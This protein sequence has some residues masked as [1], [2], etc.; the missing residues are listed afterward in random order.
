MATLLATPAAWPHILTERWAAPPTTIADAERADAFVAL[1]IAVRTLGPTGTIAEIAAS[2][3]RGRGGSG[4]PTADKWRTVSLSGGNPVVVVNGYGADPGSATDAELLGRDPWAV[5]EGTLIAA[6]VVGASE[7]IIAVRADAEAAAEAIRA[8]VEAATASGYAGEN[9]SDTGRPVWL[10]VRA[11]TGSFM[12]GEETVLLRALEG[13]RAQPDQ[14]PPHPSE[15]GL[16]GRP[17]VVNNVATLAAVPWIIRNGAAA[18]AAIGSPAAPGTALVHVRASGGD[19]VAEV[20]TGTPLADIVALLD[21]DG[22]PTA[23]AYLL[24]GPTGGILPASA[25]DTP[26]EFTAL[27][28]AGGHVGSG[29]I[30]VVDERACIVDLVRL[31]TRFAADAAC[32]KSIPCRIGLRRLSEIVDRAADG[33][34]R[35]GDGELAA[36]LTDDIVGS[37]LCDHERLATLALT[38]AMRHFDAEVH[39]HVREGR[40]PA[41]VCMPAMAGAGAGAGAGSV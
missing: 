32:G 21:A 40:C 18:Y 11:L 5:V 27:R 24:G 14:R 15:R 23:K 4:F 2:G 6:S 8:A 22:A 3:L 36:D 19:G 9:A 13:R 41:G 25:G 29:S 31:V 39:A 33:T 30:V 10:T 20:P 17:T 38:G 34:S 7:A 1:R 35:A 37:A 26:Y 16:G 28:E 12:L